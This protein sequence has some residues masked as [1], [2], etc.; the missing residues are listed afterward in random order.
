MQIV[1]PQTKSMWWVDPGWAAKFSPKHLLAPPP[2]S[3]ARWT[4]GKKIRTGANKLMD[5]YSYCWGQTRLGE[6]N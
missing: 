3:E 4:G 2:C 1:S 5:K 6:F